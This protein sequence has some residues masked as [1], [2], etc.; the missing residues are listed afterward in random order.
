VQ[1]AFELARGLQTNNTLQTLVLR[2]CNL[3]EIGMVSLLQSLVP[4][5]IRHLDIS[6]CILDNAAIGLLPLLRHSTSLSE[7]YLS[8]VRLN[9]CSVFSNRHSDDIDA[10]R[11][12]FIMSFGENTSLRKLNLSNN[13]LGNAGAEVVAQ[14]LSA[15]QTIM[16]LNL[17]ANLLTHV[18]TLAIARAIHERRTCNPSSPIKMSYLDLRVNNV[19]ARHLL[20]VL[21]LLEPCV[22]TLLI[23]R[24]EAYGATI[25]D[26]VQ[27]F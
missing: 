4:T 6:E 9:N 15:N 3:G 11:T 18:G 25:V 26:G 22:E 16:W 27:E 5:M 24:G 13:R 20:E 23:D 21:E 10:E 8:G 19:H 12:R 1:G 17:S 7:L 14:I 2:T